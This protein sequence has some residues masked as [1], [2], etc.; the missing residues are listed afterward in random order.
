MG[1]GIAATVAGLVWGLVTRDGDEAPPPTIS[2]AVT[3][4]QAIVVLEGSF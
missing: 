4:E 2:A 3:R 1:I